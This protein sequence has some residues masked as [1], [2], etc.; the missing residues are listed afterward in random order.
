MSQRRAATRM[1]IFADIERMDAHAW[2]SYLAPDAVMRIGNDDPIYGRDGCRAALETFYARI[3]GLRYDLVELWEHG[4]ATIVEANV[5]YARSDGRTVTLPV[6][7]IYRTDANDLI[8]DYRVYTD[9]APVF[10]GLPAAAA[11]PP[12]S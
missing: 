3:D 7:T 1:R 4:E 2:A 5:T 11:A 10:A 6:V 8:S 12:V 9:S